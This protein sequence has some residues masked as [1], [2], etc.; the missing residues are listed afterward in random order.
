MSNNVA[1]TPYV[2]VTCQ[3]HRRHTLVS[4]F[5]TCIPETAEQGCLLFVRHVSEVADTPSD[6]RWKGTSGPSRASAPLAVSLSAVS[7]PPPT[8]W[9]ESA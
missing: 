4:A 7:F 8:T 6:L 1:R 2:P 3:W 9:G 5:R